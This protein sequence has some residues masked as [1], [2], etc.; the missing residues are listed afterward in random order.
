MPQ[1]LV[2]I[3]DT[4]KQASSSRR[5]CNAGIHWGLV[6]MSG[7]LDTSTFVS[8]S[9]FW[10]CRR[11][12]GNVPGLISPVM[13]YISV[14]RLGPA[15]GR[16]RNMRLRRPRD[17]ILHVNIQLLL[18]VCLFVRSLLLLLLCVCVCVCVCVYVC[19][20]ARARALVFLFLLLLFLEEYSNI[21][22]T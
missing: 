20:C 11:H 6:R 12:D 1:A 17:A 15:A 5:L 4:G 10:R 9:I 22:T 19:V 13:A 18:F 21:M 3:K 14:T 7:R 8:S 2:V 16:R